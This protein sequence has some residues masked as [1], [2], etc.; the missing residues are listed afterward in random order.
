MFCSRE[1]QTT[2]RLNQLNEKSTSNF[3]I[4]VW[5]RGTALVQRLGKTLAE[6]IGLQ[7]S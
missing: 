6:G 3:T 1:Y 7:K 5:V 2:T 4:K